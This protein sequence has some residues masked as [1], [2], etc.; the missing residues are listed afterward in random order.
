MENGD[1]SGFRLMG[2][3]GNKHTVNH[4]TRYT[5][6]IQWGPFPRI[7]E[8][9]TSGFFSIF[10]VHLF[11]NFVC[12]VHVCVWVCAHEGRCLQRPESADTPGVGVQTVFVSHTHL[13]SKM[14]R[15]F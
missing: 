15:N 13:Q 9:R 6:D 8:V 10:K 1:D 3:L 5:A 11:I 14:K 2:L 4:S 7:A 12:G